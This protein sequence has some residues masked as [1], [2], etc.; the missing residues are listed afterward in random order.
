[1]AVNSLCIDAVSAYLKAGA[2]GGD[3]PTISIPTLV[4]VSKIGTDGTVV[5]GDEANERRAELRVKNVIERGVVADW[6]AMEALWNKCLET[7]NVDFSDLQVLLTEPLY[8][9]RSMRE[10]L[11]EIWFEAYKV[12]QFGSYSQPL[13]SLF[14]TGS[15]TGVVVELGEDLTQITAV[16]EGYPHYSACAR[17]LFG[18]KDLI[19]NLARLLSF[20]GHSFRSPESPEIVRDIHERLCYVAHDFQ[21]ENVLPAAHYERSYQLPDGTLL[22]IGEERFLSN[23][24]LFTPN[25]LG[26]DV[27]PLH[28]AVHRTITNSAIDMRR[29]LWSHV[30][31]CG[32]GALTPGLGD[33]LN[34]ELRLLA[35]PDTTVTVVPQPAAEHAAWHGASV[36]SMLTT[37]RVYASSYDWQD[38]GTSL[39]DRMPSNPFEVGSD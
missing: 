36:L 19:A 25:L 1:M 27:P 18:C 4:G 9:P 11:F 2:S 38:L 37:R 7:L 5:V 15:R 21:R 6:A 39:L 16:T 3:F 12:Q 14:G 35:P 23:E 17:H 34:R 20:R 24:P 28:L 31:L 13:L 8:C 29:K 22:D 32:G 10:K 26:V 33:R 30:Y